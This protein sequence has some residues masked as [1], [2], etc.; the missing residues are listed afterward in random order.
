[1]EANR[2]AAPSDSPSSLALG[3]VRQILAVAASNSDLPRVL[4]LTVQGAALAC[5]ADMAAISLMSEEPPELLVASAY[6]APG[7]VHPT[8]LPVETSLNGEVIRSARSVRCVDAQRLRDERQRRLALENG[9]RGLFVAP[10]PSPA[11]PLGT[12]AVAKKVP[13]R[14]TR[15][16]EQ[17]IHALA[18]TASLA[19]QVTRAATRGPN[20]RRD[21]GLATSEL[22]I[23][24]LLAADKTY[25]EIG[26][27]LGLSPRT[28]GHHVDRIKLRFRQSTV[29]GL[30]GYLTRQ[31][32]DLAESHSQR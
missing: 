20:R 19:L 18:N 26:K 3:L 24:V 11:G 32:L 29:H 15:R 17:L 5:R 21:L 28:I 27:V 1:M 30:I 31:G 25:K 22:K 2:L 16:Q 8:P 4:S 9:L 7:G 12:L 6:G 13:W 10:L 14:C 23:L